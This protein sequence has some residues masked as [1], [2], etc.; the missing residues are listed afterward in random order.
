MT[1]TAH[2]HEEEALA[3]D[4][5]FRRTRSL[6]IRVGNALFIT[7]AM[8]MFIPMLVGVAQGIGSQKVW[9]PYTGEP[10]YEQAEERHSWCAEEG[11]RLL[12]MAGSLGS[13]ERRWAEPYREWQTRCKKDHQP[14]YGALERTRTLLRKKQDPA[15]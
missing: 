15:R 8:V 12:V 9:N 3:H 6:V 4:P 1:T 11:R 5:K 10:V 7:F 2:D 14:L 13:L